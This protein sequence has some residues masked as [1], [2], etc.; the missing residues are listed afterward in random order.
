MNEREA[1]ENVVNA[2][3]R[4]V[5]SGLIARTW[6][7]VSCRI[8]DNHFVITPS[9]RDYLTLSPEEIVKV[10]IADLSYTGDIKPS[11]EKGIHAEIY[12]HNPKINF[13]IHTHQK[14]A[15]VLSAMG[16]DSISVDT[17]NQNIIC[18]SYALPG[19]KKLRKNVSQALRRS[20]GNAIIM[21]NHGAICFGKDDEEAF[22]V[23]SAL[24][25]ACNDF[26][27]KQYKK[28][29]NEENYD[30]D[31]MRQ[32]LL[33]RI[34]KQNILDH[35]FT[36]NCYNSKRTEDGFILYIEHKDNVHVKFGESSSFLSE[37]AKIHNAIYEKYKNINHIIH[38]S[39]PDILAISRA[40]IT[41]Y[42]MVDD[43]AQ[44]VGTKV[45][46]VINTANDIANA[47]KNTSA[48]IIRNKGALCCAAS[49]EDAFAIEMILEKNSKIALCS[50][51]FTN[52]K[53]L[54]KL[55]CMLMRF[56]Y[57]KKY[58]KQ[59]NSITELRK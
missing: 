11:S 1:K 49:E 18:A 8:S 22:W 23:A 28:I 32:F 57:L 7:N 14:N 10:S 12:K 51:L 16:L 43:F 19:T 25:D 37:E 56:V 36:G 42:P 6:G 58:S 17:A 30:P 20:N 26:I 9:G 44:I 29:S 39:S 48:L 54:S 2:G 38:A 27:V 31:R 45:K 15:S 5:K 59:M 33:N 55:D 50:S 40:N 53:P 34:K 3:K 52:V 47:L 13:V 41:L 21:K 46:T 35:E 4:L 24:E